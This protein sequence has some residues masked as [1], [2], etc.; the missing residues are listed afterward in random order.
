MDPWQQLR[1]YSGRKAPPQPPWHRGKTPVV[2]SHTILKD[3]HPKNFLLGT[4]ADQDL[5]KLSGTRHYLP[6]VSTFH[7]HPGS[8]DVVKSG[9]TQVL[10][11]YPPRT[12][13]P[14]AQHP[15]HVKP[16]QCPRRVHLER[17]RRR[18]AKE[19]IFKLFKSAGINL[20]QEMTVE[21][22]EP[23]TSIEAMFG[24]FDSIPNSLPLEIFDDD[25]TDCRTPADWLDLGWDKELNV[26][27]PIPGHA[28]LPV[29]NKTSGQGVHFDF[30]HVM[31]L[32]YDKQQNL[33]LVQRSEALEAGNELC[34]LPRLYLLFLADDPVVFVHRF[35]SACAARRSTQARLRYNLYIDCMAGAG[36]SQELPEGLLASIRTRVMGFGNPHLKDID[37]HNG[38]SMVSIYGETR[39]D[40]CSKLIH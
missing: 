7:E 36:P 23:T 40:P 6:K 18:F 25:S 30:C 8:I 33:Y 17:L 12:L 16:G 11:S 29:K 3:C 9:S 22:S 24:N 10:S 21:S 15:Y 2:F 4:A 32:E 14:K 38:S 26:F 5:H 20:E 13:E 19:D 27:Q 31:V 28:I 37:R 34:W 39:S 1:N 35:A